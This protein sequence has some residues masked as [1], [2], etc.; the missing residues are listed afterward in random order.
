MSRQTCHM[1]EVEHHFDWNIGLFS[2]KTKQ[3]ELAPDGA[4]PTMYRVGSWCRWGFRFVSSFCRRYALAISVSFD[5]LRMFSSYVSPGVA[6]KFI[7]PFCAIFPPL[8]QVFRKTR[9][10]S[11]RSSC[12][13]R[14]C[15][16]PTHDAGHGLPR[17]VEPLLGRPLWWY[18][19]LVPDWCWTV[20][21]C[22]HAREIPYMCRRQMWVQHP[23]QWLWQADWNRKRK[24]W[25]PCTECVRQVPKQ[26]R[27]R[28]CSLSA[29]T[30]SNNLRPFS[31]CPLMCGDVCVQGGTTMG[32]HAINDAASRKQNR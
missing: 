19:R 15:M 7:A 10:T 21:H 23:T 24:S 25:L 13:C 9:K 2:M 4:E 26:F 17:F 22:P 1:A 20:I 14:N 8:L 18:C 11:P 3:V 5:H 28:S 6:C 16:S 32:L 30:W 12:F 31:V 27:E 29:R